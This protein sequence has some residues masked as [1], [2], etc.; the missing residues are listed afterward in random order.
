M[1]PESES[2][3]LALGDSYTIG[4][5]VAADARWP[6]RLQQALQGSDTPLAAPDI[7]AVTG[8]TCADLEAGMDAATLTPP[9]ALVSLSI[10]VN[11]QYDGLDAALYRPQFKHLLQ[12]AIG[13]AAARPARVL[14]VS[15][16]DWS[17]TRFAREHGRNH[18]AE[19]AA[20]DAYNACAQHE[21]AAAGAV[22]VDVTTASRAYPD[23]LAADGLHPAAAH[24]QR[25]LQPIAAA[26]RMALASA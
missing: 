25:W 8:W 11:D 2:R 4:E 7:I 5:G 19:A 10:G 22:W 16:P 18:A 26:A 17:L 1:S 14:V 13:L 23:E 24:Y 9:Y 3:W 15:I 12:R 6:A 21:V 20:I